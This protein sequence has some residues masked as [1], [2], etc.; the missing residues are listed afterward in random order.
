MFLL[1]LMHV[2]LSTQSK[3]IKL[4]A[5]AKV[6]GR[7]PAKAGIPYGFIND[8]WTPA[9]AG[10]TKIESSARGSLVSARKVDMD[11]LRGAISLWS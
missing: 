6:H 8:F 9:F 3:F 4:E 7:Q 10:V 11:G 5:L 2:R 1:S